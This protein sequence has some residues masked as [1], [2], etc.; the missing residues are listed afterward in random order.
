MGMASLFDPCVLNIGARYSRTAR[1]GNQ[2]NRQNSQKLDPDY[3][4]LGMKKD[5]MK[6]I[7]RDISIRVNQAQ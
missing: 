1:S 2:V 3:R 5:R 4:N 7:P 6:N